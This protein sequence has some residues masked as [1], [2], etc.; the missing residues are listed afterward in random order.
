MPSINE[1][2]IEN[3]IRKNKDIFGDYRLPDNH[4][5]RFMYKLNKR[6]RKII[7]IV[8]YLIKVTIAT[9]IIFAASIIIWNNYIRKDRHDI[10][11]RNKI[12]LIVSKKVHT[13]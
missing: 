10:T 12:S 6:I 8:P 13:S 2:N 5:E 3:F 7:S 9:I 11:L 1:K 4:L